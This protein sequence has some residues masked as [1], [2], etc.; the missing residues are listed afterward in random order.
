MEP[1][2][3]FT[4]N[5]VNFMSEKT[6]FQQD[7]QKGDDVFHWRSRRSSRAALLLTHETKMR[8]SVQTFSQFVETFSQFTHPQSGE[9]GGSSVEVAV[10]GSNAQNMSGHKF[11]TTV[12]NRKSLFVNVHSDHLQQNH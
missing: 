11:A 3:P 9:G 2:V 8:C 6:I 5:L 12:N 7:S 4:F 10:C 1:A